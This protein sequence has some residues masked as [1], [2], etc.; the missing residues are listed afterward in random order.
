MESRFVILAR[1]Y[2][3]GSSTEVRQRALKDLYKKFI[4]EREK[5]FLDAAAATTAINSLYFSDYI[6]FDKITPQMQEAFHLAYPNVE[7]TSLA[8]STPEEAAGFLSGWKGKYFEV[9]VRDRL[10]AGEWVGDI[11]LN[12]NQVAAIAESA[13]QPG[14]DLQIFNPDGTIADLLQLKATNSLGYIQEALKRYPDIDVLTTTDVFDHGDLISG[15]VINSGISNEDLTEAIHAPMESLFDTDIG[16]FL[17]DILPGLPFLIIAISEGR[18]VMVGKKSL[19]LA[20]S[21][22]FERVAKTS[23]SMGVGALVYA[24]DGGILSLP[25]TF[26]TRIGF[27]RVKILHRNER[28]IRK[29][30]LLLEQLRLEY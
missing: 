6:D 19:A 1:R 14:W 3:D 22:A 17:E 27:D 10:N 8:Q 25:A 24:L 9:L 2:N 5:T 4:Q 28:R 23:L 21:N 11:H 29:K 30:L 18:K 20:L 16:E 13:T 7:L 26:L 15:H 12:P